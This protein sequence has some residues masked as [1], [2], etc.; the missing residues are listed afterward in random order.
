MIS[1]WCYYNFDDGIDVDDIE[2]DIN[3]DDVVG[4]DDNVDVKVDLRC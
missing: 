3:F 1:G 4:V 2:A